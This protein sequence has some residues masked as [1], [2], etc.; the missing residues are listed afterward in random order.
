MIEPFPNHID[1]NRFGDWLTG[2]TDGEGSFVLG[3]YKPSKRY[4][5]YHAVAYFRIK[6]RN[7]DLEILKRI[8]SFWQCGNLDENVRRGD[9]I[10]N[11]KPTAVYTVT[12]VPELIS[13]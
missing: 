1:R 7:D 5:H 2:F 12:S 4:V 13:T 11:A 6:L 10:P 9:K 3:F 8:R